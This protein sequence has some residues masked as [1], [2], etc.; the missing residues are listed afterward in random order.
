MQGIYKITNKINGKSYIGQSIDIEKRW[1]DHK[2]PEKKTWHYP[3][4]K[5]IKKYGIKNFD[6]IVLEEVK[7]F[8]E[9]TK[10]EYFYYKKY[11]PEY[12]VLVPSKSMVTHKKS[13]AQLSLDGVV[14][15]IYDSITEATKKTGTNRT[16]IIKVCKKQRKTTGGY[17]WK[18]I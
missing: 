3:L 6:F 13:V 8:N 1:V 16:N 17:I 10:K 2:W 5:A 7:D 12:N 14:I 15:N 11:K 9:L 18:Y 4:Y